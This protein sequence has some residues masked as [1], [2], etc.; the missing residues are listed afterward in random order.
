MESP[1]LRNRVA[2]YR[3]E[4]LMHFLH[5]RDE[6]LNAEQRTAFEHHLPGSHI[7]VAMPLE[8]WP[9]LQGEISIAF[10]CLAG[11]KPTPAAK[12]PTGAR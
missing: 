3:E 6:T 11:A 1:V 5:G 4:G 10:T 8:A 2:A 12:P 9:H 7:L